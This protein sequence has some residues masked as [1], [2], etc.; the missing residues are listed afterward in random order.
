MTTKPSATYNRHDVVVVPFPFAETSISKR[1]PAVVVSKNTIFHD[2]SGC[3]IAAMI[4]SASHRPWKS[5]VPI[6][7]LKAAGLHRACVIRL[8]LF[9]LDTRLI[10]SKIGVLGKSEQTLLVKSLARILG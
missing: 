7:N 10:E 2:D 4:T 6:K 1:R 3:V 8:K 5:D 9:T